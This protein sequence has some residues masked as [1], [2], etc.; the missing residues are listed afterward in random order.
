MGNI[1]HILSATYGK[2]SQ[3]VVFTR[4]NAA[5]LLFH[6]T[7]RMTTGILNLTGIN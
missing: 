3:V 5:D 1:F 6:K 4:I 2:V 7:C